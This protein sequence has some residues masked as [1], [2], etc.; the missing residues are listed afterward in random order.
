MIIAIANQNG[1]AS[2][3]TVAHNLAVL[4]AGSGRKVLLIDTDPKKTSLAWSSE[5]GA[6]GIWPGVPARAITGRDLQTELANLLLYYNDVMI[7][8]EGRDML[9]CRPALIAARL[10]I[11]PLWVDQVN[12]DREYNLISQLNSARMFNPGLHVLFVIVGGQSDPSDDE[13]AAIRAYVSCVM[14]ATLARTVIHQPAASHLACRLG[15]CIC[16][17]AGGRTVVEMNALYR[18]VYGK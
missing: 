10:V 14:S 17:G 11:V 12:L 16:D 5:R 3:R 4:R 1:T 13:L 18:E 8:I 9:D 7:D 2:D 15:R 6:A